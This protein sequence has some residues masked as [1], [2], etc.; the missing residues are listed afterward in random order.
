[1]VHY[2]A[3]KLSPHRQMVPGFVTFE[4]KLKAPKRIK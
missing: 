1:M 4:L 2:L 3:D